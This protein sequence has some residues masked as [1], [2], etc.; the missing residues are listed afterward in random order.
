MPAPKASPDDEEG[1]RLDRAERDDAGE[2]A[3]HQ[4]DA[5]QRREREPVEEA[6]LDVARDVRARRSSAEKS[7]PWT[8]VIASANWR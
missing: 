8:K 4:R 6:G 1:E 7:A 3:Q 5:P 2:L